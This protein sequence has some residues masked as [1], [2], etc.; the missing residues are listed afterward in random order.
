MVKI[1]GKI[2]LV[3]AKIIE[4][5]ANLP[6]SLPA[7][8]AEYATNAKDAK[9]KHIWIV[10]EPD[11]ILVIDDGHGMIPGYMPGDEEAFE[12]YFGAA[13]TSDDIRTLLKSETLKSL[14][15]MVEC[16]GFSGKL[17]TSGEDLSGVLGIGST[18]WRKYAREARF[19]TK[20]SSELASAFYGENSLE[21]HDP[22]IHVL[23]PATEEQR[24][25]F[26]LSYTIEPYNGQLY[27]PWGNP[28]SHGTRVEIERLK[29]INLNAG[30]RK[31]NAADAISRY[32]T[33]QLGQNIREGLEITIVDKFTKFGGLKVPGGLSHIVSG[34]GYKG[35]KLF[36]RDV[37]ISF[38]NPIQKA[39]FEIRVWYA[40]TGGVTQHVMLRRRKED[41]NELT[42]AVKN[43]DP[44]W[45][46]DGLNGFISFPNLP[47]SIAPWEPDKKTPVDNSEAYHAWRAALETLTE[48]LKKKIEQAHNRV[49]DEN[50]A[51]L[52][53]ELSR[54]VIEAMQ[55]VPGLED[56]YLGP[57]KPPEPPQ[58]P[59]GPHTEEKRVVA[60]VLNQYNRGVSGV[61]I[62][63]ISEDGTEDP[64]VTGESG[65]ISFG[66][67]EGRFYI[68]ME[69]SRDM[70]PGNYRPQSGWFTAR[71]DKGHREVFH[72]ITPDTR[73]IPK[74]Y[75]EFVVRW[76]P[77]G[78][79]SVPYSI[80]K[81]E[82]GAVIINTDGDA[83]VQAQNDVKTRDELLIAYMSSAVAEHYVTKLRTVTTRAATELASLLF[84]QSLLRLNAVRKSGGGRRRKR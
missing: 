13:N 81:M 69:V 37:E 70:L 44:V 43:L 5:L 3:E 84:G 33:Q 48:E 51:E 60:S 73:P 66:R 8:L 4:Y 27:D 30:S 31:D 49:R 24:E 45:N 54:V 59:P 10:I 79:P 21:S 72:V 47:M 40:P 58:D 25:S 53:K 28:L 15:W 41:V 52:G 29:A 38:G 34:G 6:S 55:E 71:K 67:R 2:K 14:R 19:I 77:L 63:L 74:R 50:L 68:K 16:V 22:P 78:D 83:Y 62:I 56:I 35:R 80:D 42:Q 26:D 23:I 12:L 32:L 76:L 75:P 65:R 7:V 18:C 39:S 9:A 64:R 46:T 61:K 20:P 1:T 36:E 11:R 17:P 57:P 82:Y